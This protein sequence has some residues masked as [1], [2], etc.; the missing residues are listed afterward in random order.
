MK[1]RALL[2][3]TTLTLAALLTGCATT[4][5]G[6]TTSTDKKSYKIGVLEI[7]QA[8]LI[9][10]VVS[11]FEASVKK[12][13]GSGVT[14]TFDV[15]NANGDQSL[16]TSIS[17]DFAGSS[18]DAFAVI[19]T[20]AVVALATQIKDRP[21]IAL[22]IGDPV[23]SKVAASLTAPGG[24]VTGS[25]DY[26]DP[27]LLLDDLTKLHP[28]MK[29]VGTLYDPSNQNMQV[30]MKALTAAAKKDGVDVAQST[31]SS[32][33]DVAQSAR[34]L[35]GRA[36][37]VL[38]GPDAL[39]VAGIDAVGAAMAGGKVPLYA[40]GGDVTVPGMVG[41]LGPDY[42]TLGTKAGVV[43]AKVL[44]GA[45]PATTAFATPGSVEIVLSKTAMATYGITVPTAL[46]S[47]TTE[48]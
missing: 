35:V 30:W 9:D 18:D 11:A 42:P 16:I 4:A 36:D 40:V 34:S 48:Q 47:V 20:P 46:A 45:S 13:L 6:T 3:A 39:V 17:R 33:A 21:V 5:A 32:S 38:V 22:A 1:R 8:Q 23:G 10:G 2:A 26:V 37:V 15:Q 25:I 31:V 14:V 19:G 27:A 44:R 29:T 7:A 24:N 41:S 43:A 28:G 12:E